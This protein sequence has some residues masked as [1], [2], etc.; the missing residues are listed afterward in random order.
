MGGAHSKGHQHHTHGHVHDPH[1]CDTHEHH[2]DE[3]GHV[4]DPHECDDHEHH[5]D[6]HENDDHEC[7]S[8][9]HHGDEPGHVQDPD[10]C[11]DHEH[12][13]HDDHHGNDHDDHDDHAHDLRGTSK[14][15]LAI[16]LIL[17]AGFMVAEVIGGIVSGS[18]ALLSDAGHMVTDAMS[19][20]LALFAMKVADRPPSAERTFGYRRAE[21]LAAM[22]NALSLWLIAAW[23]LFEA[24]HRIQ[25]VPE[26]EGGLMLVV[27]ILGLFV[28]IAAAWVLHRSSK[29]SMN[30]EG[31]LRH[32]MADLLGSVAVVI[33][34]IVIV[35][36][37]WTIIDPILSAVIALLV[38]HSSWSLTVKVF[39]VL[40]EGVPDHIDVYRL[41]S[42][43][44]D[45][46]GV[47]LIHDVHVWTISSGLEAL[48]A[49]ILIDPSYEGNKEALLRR[50]KKIAHDRY[51]IDHVTIQME[52][53]LEG[54]VEDHH[55][56]HLIAR[57][58][59]LG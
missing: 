8:H 51:G 40:L 34:G 59:P 39:K 30:V 48:T 54:C 56:E 42:D 5:A 13:D 57:S 22:L 6:D 18:L 31:A 49:H 58:K 21:V 16:A 47:T 35:T 24:Y 4:H 55:V 45:L 20:A 15:S 14:R 10:E 41:C 12:H 43:M 33:S 9:E 32:V 27:G 26:I 52:E 28:N 29:H 23:V 17:I 50:L 7:D 37:G 25:D 46:R 3:P 2:G 19:I 1:E 11:D 38:G 36:L 53:T 44:E